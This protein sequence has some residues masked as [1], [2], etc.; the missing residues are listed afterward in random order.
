MANSNSTQRGHRFID[1]TDQTFG[2]WTVL[3]IHSLSKHGHYMWMCRCECGVE[4]PVV[5]SDLRGGRSSSCHRCKILVHGGK[6]TPLYGVWKR[7]WHRC[8]NPNHPAY[9]RYGGRGITVC[10]RWLDF[11]NF[12]DD[13]GPRPTPKHTIERI[14]NDGNYAPGNCC[15]AT[16]KEQANNRCTCRKFRK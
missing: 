14:D 1:L 8:R 9:H 10:D 11:A 16:R 2:K 7:M 5:G 12:R 3:G 6:G 4:K 13:M 15:W